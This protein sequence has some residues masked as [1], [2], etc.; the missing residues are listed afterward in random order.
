MILHDFSMNCYNDNTFDKSE[1][2]SPGLSI[3]WGFYFLITNITSL[4]KIKNFDKSLNRLNKKIKYA[5][6]SI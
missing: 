4:K 5:E 6:F 2:F 1:N 3:I